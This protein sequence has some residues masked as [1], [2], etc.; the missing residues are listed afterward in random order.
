MARERRAAGELASR[1][2]ALLRRERRPLGGLALAGLLRNEGEVVTSNL[3]FRALRDLVRQGAIRKLHLAGGY[4]VAGEDREI[5]LLCTQCGMIGTVR[6]ENAFVAL[7]KAAEA[8]G[9]RVR[10]PVVEVAGICSRCRNA[11]D[12]SDC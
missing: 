7:A 12:A 10:L 4:V 11:V 1:V 2:L 9:F 8:A 6:D 5:D 3:V